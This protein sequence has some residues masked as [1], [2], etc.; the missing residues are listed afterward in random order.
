MIRISD[1]VNKKYIKKRNIESIKAFESFW[2]L[3][4]YFLNFVSD[5]FCRLCSFLLMISTKKFFITSLNSFHFRYRQPTTDL[6]IYR[7]LC[8]YK[9]TF[10]SNRA[11][12]K[13]HLRKHR[14]IIKYIIRKRGFYLLLY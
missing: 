5:F 8:W 12:L 2:R 4:Y 13:F 7:I 14:N 10:N 11:N 6:F 9:N 1:I 3:E